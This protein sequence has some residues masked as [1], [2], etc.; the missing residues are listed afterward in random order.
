[1]QLARLKDDPDAA[2]A[3]VHRA[4]DAGVNHIDTADFY[5]AGFVNPILSRALAGNDDVVVVTKVGAAT[6][7]GA[8]IPLR[9]AQRPDELRASV[10]DNLRSLGRE[11]L[12]VVNLRRTDA[13]PGLKAEGVQV[14]DIDDQ[15][16]A[17]TAMRDEGK[18]GAIGLSA[19]T[20]YGLRAAAPV[21]IACVQNAYSLIERADEPLVRACLDEG[22]A[23]VPYFPL[24]G[25]FPGSSKVADHPG[26]QAIADRIGVTAAQVGLAWLLAHAPNILL[27]PG[28]TSPTHLDENL[29]VAAV[30]LTNADLT[31]LDALG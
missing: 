21:G 20:L 28:T 25:A 9:L 4:V 23:W 29:E 5:G 17:M 19:I 12:D 3:M 10:E 8:A 22:V 1:M 16:A 7:A 15:L 13:G 2:V 11:R 6:D 18:I 27:I 14:V 26:V 24:G 31:A 30:R